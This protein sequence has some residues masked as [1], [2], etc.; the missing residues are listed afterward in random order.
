MDN[1]KYLN[2]SLILLAV[3]ALFLGI[4]NKLSPV[5]ILALII[6]LLFSL[7]FPFAGLLIAVPVGLIAWL[8]NSDAAWQMWE[9]IGSKLSGKGANE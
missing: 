8:E 9:K 4:A 1:N 2:I 5:T 6:L 7:L 3:A